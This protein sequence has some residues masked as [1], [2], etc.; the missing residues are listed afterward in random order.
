MAECGRRVAGCPSA[1]RAW[2]QR[3]GSKPLLLLLLSSFWLYADSNLLSPALSVIARE[4]NMTAEER[5]LKIAG[6]L[7]ISTWVCGGV[8][9]LAVGWLCGFVNRVRLY[10]A[11]VLI[12]EV[13]CFCT[14]FVTDFTG[15]LITRSLTGIALG[16]GLPVMWS[17]LSDWFP[18]SSRGGASAIL[19][20]ELWYRNHRRAEHLRSRG[21]EPWMARSLCDSVSAVNFLRGVVHAA[22]R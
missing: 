9:A 18:D 22:C 13:A 12:G 3:P 4:F 16:G 20:H 2:L 17:L 15:L 8:A 11:V 1:F 14:L 10:F 7:S 5:D 6:E 19:F 21:P